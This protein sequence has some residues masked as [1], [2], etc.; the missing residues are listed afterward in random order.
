LKTSLLEGEVS[1]SGLKQLWEGVTGRVMLCFVLYFQG[2][3]HIIYFEKGL[4]I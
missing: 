2:E 1:P 4:S 3:S